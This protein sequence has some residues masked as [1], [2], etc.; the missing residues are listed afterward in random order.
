MPKQ[1]SMHGDY[2]LIELTKGFF[3]KVDI[4]DLPLLDGWNWCAQKSNADLVYARASRV[5][6]GRNKGVLLHRFLLDAPKD[7]HVDHI[8][9]DGL[10]NR[11]SNLRLATHS[12]NLWNQRRRKDNRSGLKGASFIKK[13]GRWQAQIKTFG[14]KKHLGYFDTAEEAHAAYCTAAEIY[15]REY[16][17]VA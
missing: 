4:S 2:A 17:R 10:D 13:Y 9:G 14:K 8:N 3:T 5:V 12:Q 7:R 6:D 11:R 16:T 1:I 15:H